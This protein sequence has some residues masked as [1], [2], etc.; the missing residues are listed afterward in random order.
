MEL[1]SRQVHSPAAFQPTNVKG[2][3][4]SFMKNVR[5][6]YDMAVYVALIFVV[7][8]VAVGMFVVASDASRDN[9]S[10]ERFR[11][12]G[13]AIISLVMLLVFFACLYYTGMEDSP[14]REIFDKGLLF[15]ATLAGSIIGFFFG[16]SR[17]VTGAPEDEM[18]ELTERITVDAPATRKKA[19]REKEPYLPKGTSHSQEAG[20]TEEFGIVKEF[21]LV[22]ENVSA[23][24]LHP[25]RESRPAAEDLPAARAR[26]AAK[27][28]SPAKE[29]VGARERVAAPLA[30]TERA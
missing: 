2:K 26:A 30:R 29:R 20:L 6:E 3:L 13:V 11:F 18:P 27:D 24:D 25:A 4:M 14:G 1:P 12:A 9:P 19:G 17:C 15:M 16:A 23:Q 10:A 5:T 21:G 28:R 8:I 22:K 7:F